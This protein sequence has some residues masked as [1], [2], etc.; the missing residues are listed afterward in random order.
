[1]L[2]GFFFSTIHIMIAVAAD[3]EYLMIDEYEY[4]RE[5]NNLPC[6]NVLYVSVPKIHSRSS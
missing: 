2:D 3:N 1:M 4:M 5:Y 6:D